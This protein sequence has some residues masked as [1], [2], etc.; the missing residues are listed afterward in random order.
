MTL[1][2]NKTQKINERQDFT[3]VSHFLP[4]LDPPLESWQL[5][6]TWSRQKEINRA[7]QSTDGKNDLR[8]IIAF[9]DAVRQR[10]IK[11]TRGV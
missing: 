9:C 3:S 8:K 10:G 6:F 5:L 4:S 7:I 11:S 2:K 1:L